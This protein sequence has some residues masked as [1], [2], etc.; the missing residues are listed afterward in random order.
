MPHLNTPQRILLAAAGLAVLAFQSYKFSEYGM[1]GSGWV[2]ALVVG[3]AMLLPALALIQKRPRAS[4]ASSDPLVSQQKNKVVKL[5]AQALTRARKLHR[6]LPTL[7]DLP[8]IQAPEL[9][10]MNNL[11]ISSWMQYCLAYAGALALMAEWKRDQRFPQKAEYRVV[12][13]MV[14]DQ[15]VRAEEGTAKAHGLLDSYDVDRSRAWAARDMN[16]AELAMKKFADRLAAK[17]P[18]PD[19]PIVGFL[20]DKMKMPEQLRE[21]LG[22][23]LRRF[24]KETLQEFSAA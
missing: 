1:E 24:T 20:M 13:Q 23:Q 4:V 18:D 6:Q 14:V 22:Q 10:Q 15:I 19:A 7:V 3:V 8:P 17:L 11:M 2:L 9:K 16:E 5:Y 21:G 12:W